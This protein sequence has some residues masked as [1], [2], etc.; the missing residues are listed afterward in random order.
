[1]T[2]W[3]SALRLGEVAANFAEFTGP[4][5]KPALSPFPFAHGKR[6]RVAEETI[7][8]LSSHFA[9]LKPLI[10]CCASATVAHRRQAPVRPGA[11]L[12][13]PSL[14]AAPVAS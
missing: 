11:G 4:P 2:Y 12:L 7:D 3:A 13:P 14:G 8:L 5:C 10:S 6:P 9:R 1:M